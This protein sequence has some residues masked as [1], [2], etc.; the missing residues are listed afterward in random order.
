LGL[1]EKVDLKINPKLRDVM[2]TGGDISAESCVPSFIP[3]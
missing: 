2:L 3:L 1:I